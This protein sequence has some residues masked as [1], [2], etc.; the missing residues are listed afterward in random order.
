[1]KRPSI[2]LALSFGAWSTFL[3]A[4]ETPPTPGGPAGGQHPPG[5]QGGPRMSSPL[6]GALDLNKDGTIDA[7]ELNRATDSLKKL[8]K[9]G[10]GTLTED[11]YR[12][13]RPPSGRPQGGASGAP[14]DGGPPHGPP[15]E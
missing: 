4:Q 15:V 10:D 13:L 11:E 3:N 12:P 8:D 14:G 1:M 9:N 7:E 6:I 2:L 5:G